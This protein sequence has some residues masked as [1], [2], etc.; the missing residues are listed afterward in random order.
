MSEPTEATQPTAAPAVP[1]PAPSATG[2]DKA[3][4][5]LP[6]RIEQAKRAAT[7][8]ALKALGVDS[9]DAAKAAV[10]KARELEEASKTELQRYA[11]KVSALEPMA[12]RAADLEA[13]IGRIADV[14]VSRLTEEQRSA[15]AAIAGDDKARVLAT[16]EALRP[17]WN[18]PQASAP[19]A[20]APIA[21][22][23]NT[24]QK[25]P[26]SPN[27]SAVSGVDHAATYQALKAENPVMA[28]AYLS[29][30]Q[31]AIYPSQ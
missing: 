14:E 6:E 3:P 25:P 24:A 8:D 31:R 18:K 2:D 15:V 4:A 5:W 20:P 13:T 28:A 29:Q 23:A 11:D 12:K 27:A 30:H 26:P 9:I 10:S 7:A 1:P 17:T 19:N 16:I 21:A 22:P